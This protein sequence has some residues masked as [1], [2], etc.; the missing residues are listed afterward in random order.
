M[1]GLSLYCIAVVAFFAASEVA[2]ADDGPTLNVASAH[3]AKQ[4]CIN[5]CR[6]RYRDCRRMNQLPSAECQGIYQ[7]C[8][9]YSCT[10]AGPG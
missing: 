9:R 5:S 8:T 7:D 10:G 3:T 4:Q 6:A 1:R 2:R